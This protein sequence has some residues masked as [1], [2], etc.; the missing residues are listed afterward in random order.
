MADKDIRINIEAQTRVRT[1][2]VGQARRDLDAVLKD[3]EAAETASTDVAGSVRQLGDE[4][5]A[6]WKQAAENIAN[7]VKRAAR[8]SV[9]QAISPEALL[10]RVERGLV[11]AQARSVGLRTYSDVNSLE[12]RLSVL[13]AYLNRAVTAGADPERTER[14]RQA[15]EELTEELE[16]TKGELSQQNRNRNAPDGRKPPGDEREGRVGGAL[17]DELRNLAGQGL[18]ALGPLGRLLRVAGPPAL[19][20][21][22]AIG[23][24]NL[25][26]NTLRGN[27]DPARQEAISL[28]DLARQ[29]GAETNFL[30]LFYDR[31]R[32][33]RTRAELERLGFS[34]SQAAAFAA[35]LNLPGGMR[36]DTISGLTFART[37]GMDLGDTANIMRQLGVGGTFA[38]GQLGEALETFKLAMSEGIERGIAKSDTMSGLLRQMTEINQRGIATTPAALAMA[39]SLQNALAGV[40]TRTLQGAMGAE[41]QARLDSAVTGENDPAL[42]LLAL[43]TFGGRA[44]TAEQLGLTGSVAAG[45]RQVAARSPVQAMRYA[46][47][48]ARR[49]PELMARLAQNM[50]GQLRDPVLMSMFLEQYGLQGEQVLGVMGAGLGSLYGR[51][52]GDVGRFQE[53]QGLEVDPQGR[54]LIEQISRRLNVGDEDMR[55]ILSRGMLATTGSIEEVARSIQQGIGRAIGN[56]LQQ[57][58]LFNEFGEQG[59]STLQ[60]ANS[61]AA[62]ARAQGQTQARNNLMQRLMSYE[63]GVDNRVA[64]ADIFATIPNRTEAAALYRQWL[65]REGPFARAVPRSQ[66]PGGLPSNAPMNA[67]ER[68]TIEQ[69]ARRELGASAITTSGFY[70][71]GDEHRGIDF[72]IG[73]RGKGGDPI[74][75]V[76][77]GAV[78][79]RI[80]NDPKGYG[81]F[82]ELDLGGGRTVILAHLERVNVRQ[83][84]RL[85]RGDLVGLEGSTGNSTGPH[86]HMEFFQGGK[87]LGGGREG[88]I[89]QL[90]AL[91]ESMGM[92][93]QNSAPAGRLDI[94]VN[95]Q[96]LDRIQVTGVN[97]EKAEQ[98]EGAARGLIRAVLPN[99]KGT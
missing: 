20:A 41:A 54:N 51:A 16:A 73:E 62:R 43:R 97:R 47:Q 69:A 4:M 94:N 79:K 99:Y 78:V 27:N 85:Q 8:V 58:R 36:G 31:N 60:G 71:S 89:T 19:V 11:S 63:P 18:A 35:M 81:N 91:Y 42:Q 24:F 21:G 92:T 65:N 90:R 13:G 6:A 49:R 33:G 14:L 57:D 52:A 77:E 75:N 74:R 29:Y 5:Q 50:Q 3:L 64:Q 26:L 84:Q 39:A 2:G 55:I 38:R 93:Q 88:Y 67:L 48:L 37:T 98:I 22:A 46:L 10:A 95:I 12:A 83:G 70:P 30:N 40:G 82:V 53:G 32:Q 28:A 9:E 61:Q 66:R 45:Y 15:L 76:F 7:E 80:G 59:A 25:L 96:G 44:P 17:L 1:E 72:A 56:I 87:S 23:G 34:G 68:V 86:L